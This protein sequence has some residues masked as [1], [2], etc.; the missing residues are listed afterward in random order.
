MMSQ[1][2]PPRSGSASARSNTH[3][4]S[5]LNENLVGFILQALSLCLIMVL[6]RAALKQKV[7]SPPEMLFQET[8]NALLVLA[9]FQ[10][11]QV[12]VTGALDGPELFRLAGRVEEAARLFER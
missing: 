4:A 10:R 1:K 11:V 8:Q 3:F 7:G 2:S 9:P 6:I 5:A 12:L